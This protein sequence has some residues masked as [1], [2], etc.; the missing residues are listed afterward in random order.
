MRQTKTQRMTD[1]P[2]SNRPK[3]RTPKFRKA[4]PGEAEKAVSR[5]KELVER[6]RQM[7]LPPCDA[8]Q[9]V[10]EIRNKD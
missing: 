7:N 8:V 4:A 10:R 2:M 6:I 1:S 9:M 5:H 3:G